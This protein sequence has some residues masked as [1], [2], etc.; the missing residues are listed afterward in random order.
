MNSR[1]GLAAPAR[2][3]TSEQ[4]LAAAAR[5]SSV[6]LLA[7]ELGIGGSERQ[8]CEMALALDR[9]RYDVHVGCFRSGGI[10]A[11]EV[12]AGGVPVVEFPLRSLRSP[13]NVVETV[14][15]LRRYV[16]RHEI[17]IVHP[18]DISA[19]VFVGLAAWALGP[20]VI[21]TS[22]RSF[23]KRLPS[24]LRVG[25][26][27]ADRLSDGVVVNCRAVGEHLASDELVP[28][29]RIHLCHNGL[30]PVR[31][32]RSPTLSASLWQHQGLVIGTVCSLR[33]EKNLPTLLE[34]FAVC[35]A[36]HPMLRLT[37]VG[38]G[39]ERQRLQQQAEHLGIAAHC[40]FQ[41]TVSDVVPW[42]S[43]IDIFVLPST[44][45]SLSNALMEAMACG[46]A[47]IASRVG[48]NSE[49]IE[50]GVT[51]LLFES[52]DVCGLADRIEQLVADSG[53]RRQLGQ[54]ATTVIRERF[55]LGAAAQ[56]LGFIYDAAL[57]GK[58]LR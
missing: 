28:R 43:A 36:R 39:S 5:P 9:K 56:R 40:T 50:H 10:R 12:R 21:V 32:F 52:T 18:F 46:C 13:R 55:S 23:R 4:A 33:P 44:S 38:D 2:R 49:L 15:A 1:A 58:S 6:L 57:A 51:G 47:C 25:L 35:Y 41:P 30:D 22:Q 16:R 45:E 34:A 11:R 54:R 24:A 17:R 48:G 37:L 53:L 29:A 8:L 7:R 27:L 20:T 19:N 3:C 14:L 26:R 31:F 42:L